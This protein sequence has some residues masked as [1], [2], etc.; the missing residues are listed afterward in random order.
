MF[1]RI[2]ESLTFEVSLGMPISLRNVESH[3]DTLLKHGVYFLHEDLP[4]EFDPYSTSVIYIGKAIRETIFSRCCKHRAALRG[5][6]NMRPGR[7]FKAYCLNDTVAIDKLYIV[8]GFMDVEPPYLISCAE[9]FLLYRYD[10]RHGMPP[11]AN[12]KSCRA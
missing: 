7:N 4:T 2:S 11:R 5:D 9:E 10:H 12:T 1:A 8:P 3:R 6:P